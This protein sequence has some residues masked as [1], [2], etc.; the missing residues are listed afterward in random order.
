MWR[1]RSHLL[2]SNAVRTSHHLSSLSASTASR[3][4][5][6]LTPSSN[7]P[8]F[9][10]PSLHLAPNNRLSSPLSST[11]SVRLLTGRDPFTSYEITP[12]VNWGIRI[13]LEKK[14]FVVERFGKY[15][16]TL[17]SGIH[18]LIPLV[19]RIAYVHSLKEEA[20]QIPDQSAI[21]KDN[22]SILIG[23]V[24]YV[25]IVDPKLASYGVE[26]PIY[27]VVQLAQTTMRSELGKITLDKTFEERDTLNEKIVEAI[28]V[29]ATDWG[30]R[31]LRY[32]IRDISPPRGVKQAMEMQ[33]EAERRKRAQI[34]ESEGERQANINIADGHK[35]AQILASQGE[36]QALINKAQGE[37][38]AI[39][40]KAQAT[41]KGIAIVSENIK[42]SGGIEAA[43]LKIAE[44]YVGAFGNIAKEGTT[45][46]L[47]SATGNPANIMAQAFTMYKNLLGNVSSGGPNESSSLVEGA[48]VEP[49]DPATIIEDNATSLET[50]AKDESARDNG[51]TGFSLQS[52]KKGK[53]E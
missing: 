29:A 28:N 46:L 9:K 17:P 30:L 1:R 2:L 47:P 49:V 23:G 44:Q 10:P 31:C 25:K 42:K 53:A 36:K 43:S 39:I 7:S 8:L 48:S 3:G 24:L 5:T 21:T 18:F 14:A 35:S 26:N 19:D 37:A 50:K 45:I 33:A 38:E 41:A 20:I 52:S 32:E 22:V 51:E 11:I 27:A 16:K 6:L 34:L 40:A 4:R 15:L 13:V 12:P